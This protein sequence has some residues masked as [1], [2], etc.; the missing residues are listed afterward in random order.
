MLFLTRNYKL[1]SLVIGMYLF[2]YGRTLIRLGIAQQ[3]M[4][5]QS[6][7]LRTGNAQ[8][9]HRPLL[10]LLSNLSISSAYLLD[11]KSYT[12]TLVYYQFLVQL[13]TTIILWEG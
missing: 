1:L 13:I 11:V 3:F 10:Q 8:R 2:L 7:Q 4:M 9:E 5:E 6:G 12:N